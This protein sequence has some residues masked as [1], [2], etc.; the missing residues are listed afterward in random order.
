VV[1]FLWDATNWTN[2]SHLR[3][4]L[5]P[6]IGQHNLVERVLV[7]D[8]EQVFEPCE[9]DLSTHLSR[10]RRR[11][12]VHADWRLA[13]GGPRSNARTKLSPLRLSAQDGIAP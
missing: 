10:I 4:N 1:T 8:A 6:V 9:E 3:T 2:I 13:E 7:S 5:K 11:G 12:G